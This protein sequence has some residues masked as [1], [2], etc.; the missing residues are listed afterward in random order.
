MLISRFA[1]ILSTVIIKCER[2]ASS[3]MKRQLRDCKE[4]ELSELRKEM[5]VGGAVL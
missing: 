5:V 1:T 2:N 3:M 4:N